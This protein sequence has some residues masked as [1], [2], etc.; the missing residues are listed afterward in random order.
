MKRAALYA[1]VSTEKQ[2][3]EQ[4][5]QT[6]LDEV[7][8]AIRVDGNILIED[9]VYQDEGWSGAFLER[10]ALDKLRQDARQGKFDILY[11]YDKGRL[12]RRFVHQEIIIDELRNVHI[13]FKSLHDINGS[14]P[15]EQV[16]GGV[17]GIFHE[18]ERVK[19]AER[20]RLAKLSKVRNGSLLG[21]NPPYGYDYIPVRG[22]GANKS[23][24]HFE[25][26]KAEAKV[27]RMIFEWVGNEGISLREVVRR[28]YDNGL[29]PRKSKR[30]MWTK[31]PVS[32]LII[33]ETYIGKHYYYKS[34]SCLPKEP[35]LQKKHYRHT[36]KTSRRQRPREEWIMVES[37]RIVSDELFERAQKQ[38]SLNSKF[39]QRNK[40]NEYLFGGLVWCA[41]GS[42]RV[43]EGING[44]C[45]YRC[46]NR[47]HQFPLPPTCDRGGVN[48]TVMDAVAWQKIVLLLTDPK[49]IRDQL[50]RYRDKHLSELNDGKGEIRHQYK[51]LKDEERRYA[52]AYG[53]GLLSE[54]IYQERMTIVL[55]QQKQLEYALNTPTDSKADQLRDMN[56]D[57]IVKRFTPFLS[58][59][60]FEDKLFTVRKLI[61]KVVA[62]KEEVILC[63]HIPVLELATAGKVELRAEHRYRYCV[64]QQPFELKLTMP[65]TDRG[66]RGYSDEYVVEQQ[67]QL[68]N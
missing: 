54:S 49:L 2:R 8:S 17:M 52:T 65:P 24:G 38:L 45:Y 62:T 61:D 68:V 40:K 64:T 66:G 3:D 47:L 56:V 67:K 48:V 28:L 63:G 35:S 1:R 23:N 7:N 59:L 4:T 10:P 31:G 53:Q 27:V 21:Y 32:R 13:E 36:N 6:Q 37:P 20:F 12:S 55:K 42:K 25:I 15:E 50:A 41:C 26:N 44:K 14:S 5:I 34:E 39:A 19:I 33:N 18:Y 46:T 57:D 9:G 16:M 11:V 30:D 51:L 43:G 60:S 58:N 29:T 22:K